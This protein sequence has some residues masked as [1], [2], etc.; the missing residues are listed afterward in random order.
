MT[1]RVRHAFTLV[2][3][4]VVISIIGML[5]GLLLPAVQGAR[6]AGRRATC[7]SNQSNVAL[8]LLNYEN[9]RNA[10]PPMRKHV[11]TNG[12]N[13]S[14]ATWVGMIL[15]LLEQQ[16]AWDVIQACDSTNGNNAAVHSLA[17]P[18]MK[19]RSSNTD[20]KS[21]KIDYVVNGGYQN[22]FNKT[23]E[24]PDGNHLFEPGRA[25]DSLF[26]DFSGYTKDDDTSTSPSTFPC[27]TTTSMDIADGASN[28][29]LL[30]ENVDAGDW[31]SY[32]ST[33]KT[34]FDAPDERSVAFCY[35]FNDAIT[36][37]LQLVTHSSSL[38]NIDSVLGSNTADSG[39]EGNWSDWRGYSSPVA[40]WSAKWIN[41]GRGGGVKHENTRPS[42]NHPGIVVAAFADRG[43]RPI[44]DTMD[45]YIF[46]R[47]C[48]P[49]SGAVINMSDIQ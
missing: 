48:Q 31:I 26:M 39:W 1:K 5:A 18:V 44:S 7:I 28:V 8:A 2:E 13:T 12:I 38:V 42:S 41:L 9:Q 34:L 14:N 3:L 27:K 23:A 40:D 19:C 29:L 30:S 45:K 37:N 49:E 15:P 22:V 35:P 11:T 32:V 10:F 33:T 25:K 4:L 21:T 46:I 36:N 47:I 43:V 24:T 20:R 6:E 17:L 16:K